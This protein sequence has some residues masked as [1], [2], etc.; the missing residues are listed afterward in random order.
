MKKTA[1]PKPAA[2][3]R[4]GADP[5]AAYARSQPPP[6]RAICERLRALIDTALPKAASKVWHG[7]PVWFLDD[8]PVAGYA[9]KAGKIQLLF[10]NGQAFDE[11]GL[12]PVGK[13]RAAEAL[14][15]DAAD[16][17]PA[18]VR[19]WLKKAGTEVLDSRAYFKKLRARKG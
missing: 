19:R 7:S 10:W 16:I 4:A 15:T 18:A 17:D 2:R 3:P 1:K 14:F 5:I 11:P 9:A 13:H 6:L 12:Q 8:N